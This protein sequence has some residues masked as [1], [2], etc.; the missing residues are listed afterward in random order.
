[1]P[2]LRWASTFTDA[3]STKVS[4]L[5]T[6]EQAQRLRARARA[7]GV[8]MGALLAGL[9]AEIPAFTSGQG[10]INL[11]AGLVESSAELSTL[12]RSIHHLT[13][14]L[15][16]GSVEAAREY[17]AMLGT[18]GGDVQSHL[19]LASAALAELRPRRSAQDAGRPVV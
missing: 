12:N 5:L 4:I 1:M 10:R 18:L 7:D 3:R 9:A 16:E 8:S 19:R 15:R 11:L 6:G 17:S 14:L 13:T 2:N